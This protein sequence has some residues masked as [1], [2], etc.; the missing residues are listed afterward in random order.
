MKIYLK[1]IVLLILPVLALAQPLREVPVRFML[2]AAE[3]AL[4]NND[5]YNALE[6][7]EKAYKEERN[8]DLA[9]LI[10]DLH[11]QIRDYKR[12]ENWYNR[13]LKRDKEMEY[14]DERFYYGLA[15]KSLGRYNDAYAEFQ[16]FIDS[17]DMEELKPR[18]RL[19]MEGMKQAKELDENNDV[20][21]KLLDRK[22]NSGGPEYG[23]SEYADGTLYFSSFQTN[24]VIVLDGKEDVDAYAKIYTTT[25][26][27]KGFAKPK[28]LPASINRE[29]FHSGNVTFSS[30][31]RRMFFTRSTLQG[32]ELATSKL[33]VSSKND[34]GWAPPIEIAAL[35]GDFLVRHPAVGELYGNDVLFFS[36]DM[37]GGQGGFDIYYATINGDAFASPVNLGETV[38]TKENDITPFYTDGTLYFSSDGYASLGGYDV[39]ETS[40]NGSK[41]SEVKNIGLGY[42]SPLDDMY[43]TTYNGGQKGYLISNR[44]NEK[45]RNLKSK[46]CCD[47]I[48]SFGIRQLIIDLIAVAE[49][50]EGPMKGS[51][52]TLVDLSGEA[53]DPITK[54]NETL[55]EYTFL[56]DSDKPY[57]LVFGKE[58]Y[59]P[60]SL[61]FNTVGILDDFTINKSMVLK[62]IPPEPVDT[63]EII[64]EVITI[65]QAIRLTNI[66]YDLD[67]DKIL[68]DAETDLQTLYDLLGQ[69]PSM[70]IELSS[71]TDAQGLSNYNQRLS[72]RRAESAKAWLVERGVEDGRVQTVGYGEEQILNQCVNG[73]R[74]SDE[75]HRLNRR[76]EFKILE[77]PQSIEIKK[78]VQ[79]EVPIQSGRQSFGDSLPK[80]KIY[81]NN[82]ALGE[83]KKG[84]VKELEFTVENVGDADLEIEIITTCHCT[85]LDYSKE[86]LSPGQRMVIKA[87]YD[88]GQKEELREYREV[89]NIISNV[90]HIVDEAIFTVQVVQ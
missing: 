20:V 61:E 58:G 4:D 86:P 57:K 17:S 15:L 67:D 81:N 46:T 52:I 53:I 66:Y 24:K 54:T 26:G 33:F 16:Y 36:A 77:G 73:V 85:E 5:Y 90:E 3:E 34:S 51:E 22:V 62:P 8:Y 88:S 7:Y 76:T 14:I 27:D 59:Y 30:D 64:T 1:I 87:K 6:W 31:G 23:A 19:E 74:C 9:V 21:V 45:K 50:E 80:L 11:M 32:E 83:V 28:A 84:E 89:I 68:P 60:D 18:A 35:N 63:T 71:H 2:D 42:N 55:D 48:Y 49:D 38:N 41:W 13:V 72:Q 10:A 37:E 43:F 79:K 40:W 47:D 82:V 29:G 75:E 44:P 56:L 69:Y 25:E 39:F 70:V 12:A 65:N 78:E